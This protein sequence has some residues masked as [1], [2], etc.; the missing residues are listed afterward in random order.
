MS[1]IRSTNTKPELLVRSLIHR[2]GFRFRL[3]RKDL[4]GKPDIV[5]PRHQKVIFV[6]GCFWHMHSCRYG[7][8]VPATNTE[9][10]QKKRTGNVTRDKRNQKQLGKVGWSVLTVWECQTKGDLS[11]LKRR[12]ERFLK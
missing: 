1:R 12:L 7:S 10:W 2:M 11:G 9:F 3:H 4:P 5:L 8:V 6:Y